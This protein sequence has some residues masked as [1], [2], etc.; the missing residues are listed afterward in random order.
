MLANLWLETSFFHILLAQIAALI[1][2]A[3]LGEPRRF[4]PL[5]AFG[6]LAVALEKKLNVGQS[7]KIKGVIAWVLAVLPLVAVLALLLMYLAQVSAL[8]YW[9]I[10]VFVLYFTLGLKSLCQHA[11]RVA[12]PLSEGDLQQ[13]RQKVAW[14]VSR[15]TEHMD[16]TQINKACIESVLENG[17]DAVYGALFWFAIVG[18]PGALLYRLANTLDACWGYRTEHFVH[19]G[20]CAARM[21]DWLSFIPARICSLAYSLCGNW[22]N[23]FASWRRI[24]IWRHS[25]GK[26][27]ASPNAGIVMSSGAGALNLSLG[28]KAVYEGVEQLKPELGRG[29]EPEVRDIY[30]SLGLLNRSLVFTMAVQALVLGAFLMA[31][32]I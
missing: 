19:F 5:V 1:L 24:N 11:D 29:Q 23:A 2:D 10:S 17:T 27:F 3:L 9:V 26:G 14:L 31:A 7:K 25:H 12:R 18:A 30:R 28:G 20:F 21:D 22:R 16:E 4:H 13:G 8:L 6:A 15:H 32:A